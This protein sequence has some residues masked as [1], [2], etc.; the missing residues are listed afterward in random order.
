MILYLLSKAGK[1]V[2]RARLQKPVFLVLVEALG[3]PGDY[4]RHL[5]GPYSDQV[6]RDSI[7]L[8]E[9]GLVTTTTHKRTTGPGSYTIYRLTRRGSIW[10]EKNAGKLFKNRKARVEAAIKTYLEMPTHDLLEYVYSKYVH[11]PNEQTVARNLQEAANL[12]EGVPPTSGLLLFC[13]AVLEYADKAAKAS[14]RLADDVHRNVLPASC[15]EVIFAAV[16][17]AKEMKRR[18]GY[19]ERIKAEA[20][21]ATLSEAFEGIQRIASKYDLLPNFYEDNDPHLEEFLT[22]EEF[23]RLGEVLSSPLEL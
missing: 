2:G 3:D 7:A 19:H 4:R 23:K 20:T 22:E 9:M 14:S 16:E 18:K 11:G 6:T 1:I 15:N 17:C 21:F 13:R 8:E 5:Y 10:I 12:L